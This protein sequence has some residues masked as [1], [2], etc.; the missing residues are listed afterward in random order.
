M[1]PEVG[2]CAALL[3]ASGARFVRMTGSGSAVYGVYAPGEAQ[4]ALDKV[5]RRFGDSF[6][7]RTR[8]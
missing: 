2:E 4:R 1:L 8:V 6:V 3:R 7:T 5:R